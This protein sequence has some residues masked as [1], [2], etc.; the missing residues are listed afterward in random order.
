M[1]DGII[2]CMLYGFVKKWCAVKKVGIHLTLI[3]GLKSVAKK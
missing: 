1:Y 3:S 2:N